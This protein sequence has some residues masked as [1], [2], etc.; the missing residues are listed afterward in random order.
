MLTNASVLSHA[1]PVFKSYEM[2]WKKFLCFVFPPLE[3]GRDLKASLFVMQ[4]LTVDTY[5]AHQLLMIKDVYFV[6][7]SPESA[8]CF[9]LMKNILLLITLYML[10]STRVRKGRSGFEKALYLL[11]FHARKRKSSGES[12]KRSFLGSTCFPA[13]FLLLNWLILSPTQ[14]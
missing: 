10:L 8:T 12:A 5:I 13:L 6:F 7:R 3:A 14:L 11:W 2:P 4:P 9:H 1:L